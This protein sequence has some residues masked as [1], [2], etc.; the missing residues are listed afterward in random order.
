MSSGATADVDLATLGTKHGTPFVLFPIAKSARV[1][2]E[3]GVIF[4]RQ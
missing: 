1:R 3:G 2:I 4:G